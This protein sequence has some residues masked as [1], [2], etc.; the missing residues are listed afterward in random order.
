MLLLL[1]SPLFSL[2]V[3]ASIKILFSHFHSIFI[4]NRV[5]IQ[6]AIFNENLS[7][8]LQWKKKNLSIPNN[9][10]KY[11]TL[12]EMYP[13][14]PLLTCVLPIVSSFQR[15]RKERLMSGTAL[16][17]EIW[18]TLP[19]PAD[20]GQY[21]QRQVMLIVCSLCVSLPNAHNHSLIVRKTSDKFQSIKYLTSTFQNCLGHQN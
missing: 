2:W 15:E 10:C 8:I 18:Q 6:P 12:K 9:L 14:S 1:F 3:Y 7:L 19:Q 11:L 13:N 20:S 21:R 16:E 17:W 4:W 5:F